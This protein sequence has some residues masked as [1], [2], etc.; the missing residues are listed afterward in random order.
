MKLSPAVK[1]KRNELIAELYRLNPDLG[2]DSAVGEGCRS[3]AKP[4]PRPGPAC[5]SRRNQPQR[6]S[7]ACQRTSWRP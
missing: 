5:P 2:Y 6:T 7:P 4:S 1:A 3:S